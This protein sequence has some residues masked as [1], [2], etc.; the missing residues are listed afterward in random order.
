MKKYA[1]FG[2][3]VGS[4]GAVCYSVDRSVNDLIK[5]RPRYADSYTYKYLSRY[6]NYKKYLHDKPIVDEIIMSE[7][8]MSHESKMYKLDSCLLSGKDFNIIFPDSIKKKYLYDN[9]KHFGMNYETGVATGNLITNNQAMLP[10]K[11]LLRGGMH[12]FN[13]SAKYYPFGDLQGYKYEAK[14]AIPDSAY[15]YISNNGCKT[16]QFY[17]A[18]SNIF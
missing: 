7:N 3:V 6:A 2:F 11:K 9:Y 4:V 16:D 13:R 18:E 15:V 10:M 14:V 8:K 5:G 17:L 1:G 12:F